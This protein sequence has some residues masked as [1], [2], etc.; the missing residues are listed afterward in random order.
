MI[1]QYVGARYVP[2]FA[3]PTAWTSGTSYEALT[4]VTYNNSS[5]TSKMPVP[6]TVGNPADNPDYWALT[7]NYNAQVE[8]YRQITAQVQS[9]LNQEITE[10]KALI[11]TDAD[12]NTEINGRIKY[13]EPSVSDGYESIPMVSASGNAYRLPTVNALKAVGNPNPLLYGGYSDGTHADETTAAIN[14]AIEN[15][16][17]VYFPEGTYLINSTI[18]ITKNTSLILDPNAIIMPDTNFTGNWLL[19]YNVETAD[20]WGNPSP[21]TIYGGKWECNTQVNGIQILGATH[22]TIDHINMRH[23]L[24]YGIQ[25]T[26][27]SAIYIYFSWIGSHYQYTTNYTSS[28]G[29]SVTSSDNSFIGVRV[30]GAWT[31]FDL[32]GGGDTLINCHALWSSSDSTE[33]DTSVGFYLHGIHNLIKC[34]SDG[35]A[36]AFKTT[37]DTEYLTD[38]W[39]QWWSGLTGKQVA[40]ETTSFRIKGINLTINFSTTG[41]SHALLVQTGGTLNDGFVQNLYCNNVSLLEATDVG[42]LFCQNFSYSLGTV[43]GIRLNLVRVTENQVLFTGTGDITTTGEIEITIPS[44][45]SSIWSGT[46]STSVALAA[47]ASTGFVQI[48]RNAGGPLHL[49]SSTIN[50]YFILGLVMKFR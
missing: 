38:C 19:T 8:E 42:K 4:I 34:Y 26:S 41:S 45:L 20:N 40:M 17:T 33:Y 30:F 25:S 31:G 28:V 39:C 23:F 13:A 12:G 46:C 48:Y 44:P 9:G 50:Q 36:T 11:D 47:N 35:Y 49:Y 37:G 3:D 16:D 10:R 2:K 22:I 43:A 6:A 29:I 32:Q 14:S 5:Y 27:T 21:T 7:G 24:L 15:N 1:R 18:E